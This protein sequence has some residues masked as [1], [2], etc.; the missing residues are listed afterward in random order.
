MKVLHIVL[1]L[2]PGGLEKMTI[3]LARSLQGKGVQT[4][5]A[6][7][8]HEGALQKEA[9]EQGVWVANFPKKDGFDFRVVWR[10]AGFIRKNRFD[11]VHTHNLAPLL[12]GTP[13]GRLAGCATVNTRHGRAGLI[14]PSLVWGM[15]QKVITV[16]EDAK[17]Q[18][19]KNNRIRES[20]VEVIY[21]A[22]DTG[23]FAN[24]PQTDARQSYR[25]LF[26]WKDDEYVFG[27]IARLSPEKDHETLI[28][29]FRN[30]AGECPCARLAIVGSG[31]LL[32]DLESM[33]RDSGVRD[34]I[35]FMGY[36]R[37]I[38]FLLSA[39]D[40]VVLSTKQE[41]VSITLLEAMA[42]ARPVIATKV[43]GNPEVIVDGETGLL[44]P[45]GDHEALAESMINVMRN[46]DYA[47]GLGH[48]AR[49]RARR[50]F[51]L[52]QMAEKYLRVYHSIKK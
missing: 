13:A 34:R 7:L 52:D 51:H 15:T 50:M 1:S 22:I 40:C 2:E 41:G 47:S 19:L 49:Q 12:Y 33:A 32:N 43:G 14:A 4:V 42:A 26:N 9:E 30:V 10:L 28:R 48:A 35:D 21:N 31:P 36:R 29:A 44:T 39:M 18:L 23:R 3:L 8:S 6:T 45:A 20:K 37:E 38:P 17:R 24:S 16:S 46:P 25:R 11:V 27:M 5:L